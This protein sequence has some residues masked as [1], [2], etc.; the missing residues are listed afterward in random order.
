MKI[1]SDK[2]LGG[3]VMAA[4]LGLAMVAPATANDISASSIVNALEKQRGAMSDASRG[5]E[6]C[7]GGNCADRAI[8]LFQPGKPAQAQGAPEKVIRKAEPTKKQGGGTKVVSKAPRQ[9][10]AKPSKPKGY[11]SPRPIPVKLPDLPQGQR[12][13]LVILFEF[14]S[15][16]IRPASRSQLQELCSAI[17]QMRPTD[18]FAIIGHTDA[19]GNAQ[20]NFNLSQRRAKEVRRHLIT[21]CDVSGDRLEAFGFG[22]ERLLEGIAGKSDRQR[23][24]EIQLNLSS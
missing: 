23:R 19:S 18:K 7:V 15:A 24:V 8:Q 12:L 2:F 13:D 22:E 20:Y 17:G 1:I 3:A 4:A 14:D 16:F 11:S 5:T 21:E 6:A 9:K 10:A